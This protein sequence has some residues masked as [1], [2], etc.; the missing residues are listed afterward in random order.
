MSRTLALSHI[1]ARRWILALLTIGLVA[2]AL[3]VGFIGAAGAAEPSDP[4]A[5]FFS[6]NATTCADVGDSSP[7]ILFTNGSANNSNADVSGTVTGGTTLNVTVL[8][9]NIQINAVVVKAGNG[10]NVY[11]GN[12]PNM[13]GPL[14]GMGENPEISHWFVCYG[15]A[16]PPPPPPPPPQG[17]EQAEAPAPVTARARFTG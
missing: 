3:A 9:P 12:F 15:P 10:Y 8:N 13:I 14:V 1:P 2:T 4:R 6:G 17:V 16:T 7:N 5:E 11:R